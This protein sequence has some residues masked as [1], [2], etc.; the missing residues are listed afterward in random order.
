MKPSSMI[1]TSGTQV[2]PFSHDDLKALCSMAMSPTLD[3]NLA[4]IVRM[5][6]FCHLGSMLLQP[7]H[8]QSALNLC[9]AR[10][11]LE[12][13]SSFGAERLR[14][15]W[16]MKTYN[17]ASLSHLRDAMVLNIGSEDRH[18]CV[19]ELP[20]R[21]RGVLV[22]DLDLPAGKAMLAYLEALEQRLGLC[23]F[24]KTNGLAA[25]PLF[26]TGGLVAH[27][28]TAVHPVYAIEAEFGQVIPCPVDLVVDLEDKRGSPQVAFLDLS[29][30]TEKGLWHPDAHQVCLPIYADIK[31][32][33]LTV[34]RPIDL[35]VNMCTRLTQSEGLWIDAMARRHL[36]TSEEFRD[37]AAQA[38][39][40]C[41]L[42]DAQ[43]KRIE[44]HVELAGTMVERAQAP[45][46]SSKRLR[47]P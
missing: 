46:A 19:I 39:L 27:L 4:D 7:T 37:H 14:A 36:F 41:E 3:A 34:P 35:A 30:A 26:L 44:R 21:D 1:P 16:I 23:D 47:K 13:M 18:P 17:I 28:F 11:Q 12:A 25:V 45:K 22:I 32:F 40:E 8:P 5:S 20:A 33:D 2:S 31:G 38:L 15:S 29:V 24:Q 42:D 9:E 10:R 43:I 6:H